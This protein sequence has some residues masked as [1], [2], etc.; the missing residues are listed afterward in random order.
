MN[1]TKNLSSTRISSRV[2][3]ELTQLL[4]LKDYSSTFGDITPYSYLN[5]WWDKFGKV[6]FI[7]TNENVW[8]LLKHGK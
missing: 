2:I 3:V 8:Y 5:F 7:E 6:I 1:I 4:N